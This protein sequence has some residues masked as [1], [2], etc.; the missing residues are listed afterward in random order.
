MSPPQVGEVMGQWLFVY[1]TCIKYSYAVYLSHVHSNKGQAHLL[2]HRN[3][4]F[5]VAMTGDVTIQYEVY[6]IILVLL[7]PIQVKWCY[8]ILVTHTIRNH[9]LYLEVCKH[10]QAWVARYTNML[11]C[12]WRPLGCSF[13]SW[14]IFCVL[15]TLCPLIRC[16]I[17]YVFSSYVFWMGDLNF[18]I[19][20]L[21]K[22]EIEHRIKKGELQTMWP[23][24]QV[25]LLRDVQTIVGIVGVWCQPH[26]QK[27]VGSNPP[28]THTECPW[29]WRCNPACFPSPKSRNRYQARVTSHP[30]GVMLLV[31]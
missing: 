2:V 15:F 27:I 16:L 18:R 9:K 30:G 3:G 25:L 31:T 21:D 4:K 7:R 11:M 26:N 8:Q 13:F 12:D 24:D 10:E 29:A 1:T 5:D 23:L 28:R 6:F 20:D 14:N 17:N 19:D 22:S